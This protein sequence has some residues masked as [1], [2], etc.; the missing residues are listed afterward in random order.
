[1]RAKVMATATLIT[2][3]TMMPRGSV[4]PRRFNRTERDMGP[5]LSKCRVLRSVQRVA[6]TR[7]RTIEGHRPGRRSVAAGGCQRDGH[8]FHLGRDIGDGGT[9]DPGQL[10]H[11]NGVAGGAGR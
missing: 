10:G 9:A 7:N 2:A 1:M 5:S 11:R 3:S 8:P 4:A 6:E